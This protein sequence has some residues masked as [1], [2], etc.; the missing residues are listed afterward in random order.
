MEE[1]A[2]RAALAE[3]EVRKKI[4]EGQLYALGPYFCVGGPEFLGAP[5]GYPSTGAVFGHW[6]LNF[7]IHP[8]LSYKLERAL[9][10]LKRLRQERFESFRA[11]LQ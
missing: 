11:Y 2:E 7:V 3:V 1:A 4:V 8:S 10:D 6:D 5:G 9:Q